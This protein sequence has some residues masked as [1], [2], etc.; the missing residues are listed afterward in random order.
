MNPHWRQQ[1][2]VGFAD[3]RHTGVQQL[4]LKHQFLTQIFASQVK[5]HLEYSRVLPVI[6]KNISLHID[7][8]SFL[9]TE[10]KN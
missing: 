10:Q 8:D 5:L 6:E 2:H 4:L 7:V 3:W 9:L 1:S